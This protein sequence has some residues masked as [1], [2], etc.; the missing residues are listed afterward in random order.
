MMIKRG[1]GKEATD[2][3]KWQII[4]VYKIIRQITK[5]TFTHVPNIFSLLWWQFLGDAYPVSDVEKHEIH[6]SVPLHRLV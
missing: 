5:A 4:C 3:P 6:P 2:L 1:L